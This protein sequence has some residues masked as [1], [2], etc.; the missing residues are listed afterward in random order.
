MKHKAIA[1]FKWMQQNNSDNIFTDSVL[2]KLHAINLDPVG[3]DEITSYEYKVS[4]PFLNKQQILFVGNNGHF[5]CREDLPANGE[6][7]DILENG[8][9]EKLIQI[10]FDSK[11]YIDK[12]AF[13]EAITVQEF[14]PIPRGANPYLHDLFHQGVGLAG[15]WE[16]MFSKP[17]VTDENA[18][19]SLTYLILVNTKT[20]RRFNL[21]LTEANKFLSEEV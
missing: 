8:I 7:S 15:N 6:F 9:A 4:K 11:C 12:S 3:S 21:D 17:Q 19:P 2:F 16:V 14:Q 13:D 20:G 1:I 18:D 5:Y 10:L